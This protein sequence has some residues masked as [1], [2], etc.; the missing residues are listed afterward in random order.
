MKNVNT[1]T[2]LGSRGDLFFTFTSVQLDQAQT[3][4]QQ[5][6]ITDMYLKYGTYCKAFTTVMMHPSAVKV[7][8]MNKSNVRIHHLIKWNNTTPMI[9]NNKY[10]KDV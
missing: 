10:K 2:T 6:G 3:Q 4:S 5:S 8:M 9:I 1:Y 7:S